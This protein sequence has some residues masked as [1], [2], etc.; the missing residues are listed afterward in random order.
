MSPLYTFLLSCSFSLSLCASSFRS[1]SI[2]PFPLST[3]SLPPLCLKASARVSSYKL[4]FFCSLY[5][6]GKFNHHTERG[7]AWEQ[8]EERKHFFC[9]GLYSFYLQIFIFLARTWL[10]E[11]SSLFF[12]TK[13]WLRGK[14]SVQF[15]LLSL[16][17]S[18]AETISACSVWIR[19]THWMI[20]TQTKEAAGMSVSSVRLCIDSNLVRFIQWEM[21]CC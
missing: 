8:K 11:C 13:L 1:F 9:P 7:I 20:Y 3:L 16:P 10:W 5:I 18:V 15:C 4:S 21:I 12:L 6:W 2:H 19:T 17:V 14:F